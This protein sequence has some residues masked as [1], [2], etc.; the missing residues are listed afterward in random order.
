MV[1][2]PE[3][4]FER[5]HWNI[6]TQLYARLRNGELVIST[7]DYGEAE[8]LDNLERYY[9]DMGDGKLVGDGVNN[10]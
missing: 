10:V 8:V 4:L 9:N 7:T 3:K 1:S 2:I 5:L 6:E